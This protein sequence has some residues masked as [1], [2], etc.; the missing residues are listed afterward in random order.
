MEIYFS[1]AR[2][3]L[4][5][6]SDAELAD[7]LDRRQ[8]VEALRKA[9]RENPT[10]PKRHHHTVPRPG[11]DATL[12]LMPAW[13]KNGPIGIKMVTVFPTNADRDLPSI[14]G[15]YT[16][17]DSETGIPLAMMDGRILTLFRT[18]ATSVLAATYLAPKN[19]TK[20]LMVGTGALA[21]HFAATY[22]EALGIKE[23][24]I[25][26]RSNEKAKKLARDLTSAY[27]GS[28]VVVSATNVLDASVTWADVISCATLSKTPLING[29]WLSSGTFVDL[30]G[31]Y[32]PEMREA[33]DQVI[34]R[35][36]IF[37]DTREGALSEA[38]DIMIPLNNGLIDLSDI[39]AD[40]FDLC[41]GNH[42][43]RQDEDE[44]TLF[45]SSGYALEDLVAAQLVYDS[46]TE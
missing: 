14:Y 24:K 1:Q 15:T 31:A 11:E 36:S 4:K 12:L 16:L 22:I 27:M 2:K 29:D 17:L 13:T 19:A 21:P 10:I 18:A 8:L 42:V 41:Q 44:I 25:W 7:A 33:D 46:V 39:R 30:V 3:S 34:R 37:V 6:I 23:V 35:A 9:F 32:T 28:D 43:G 40:L 45:K 26:G 38:G 5:I 20:L